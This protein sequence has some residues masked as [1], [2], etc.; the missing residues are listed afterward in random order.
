MKRLPLHQL[1]TSGTRDGTKF[2]RDDGAWATPTAGGGGTGAVAGPVDIQY[3]TIDVDDYSGQSDAAVRLDIPS[4]VAGDENTHPSVLYFPEQWNGWHYW[5]AFTPLPGHN[6][7]HEDPCIAVSQDGTQWE[8]P[9][10][11]TNP[12]DDATGSTYNSDTELAMSPDGLTLYCIWRQYNPNFPGAEERILMRS[13]TDGITW[14]ATATLLT[15]N[16]ATN[17]LASPAV[18]HDGTQWVMWTCDYV[19]APKVMRRHAATDI[20]GPWTTGTACTVTG[21]KSG[22]DIWHLSVV[23]LGA[24]YVGVLNDCSAGTSGTNGDLYLM[25]ST[26][27]LIWTVAT[28]ILF[29]RSLAGNYDSLYRGTIVPTYENGRLEFDLWHGAW[30]LNT[31]PI[32]WG[33]YRRRLAHLAAGSAAATGVDIEDESALVAADVTTLDF[34][35]AGV[36]VASAGAG[37]VVVTIPGGSGGA[38]A[39]EL[40]MQDGVTAPPVP[41]ETE[42]RDD[43]LYEG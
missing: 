18:L 1:A 39:G 6:D 32:R 33:I 38:G 5:M 9:A 16:V 15:A 24:Q 30:V 25:R 22:R 8:T 40:L 21:V 26:D 27:G 3:D 17:G 10:G 34:Q 43:W 13:S 19:A 42:A 2:L 36:S 29:A 4:H 7:D 28:D 41:L 37:A 31:G 23:Q 14:T 11:L 35:G 12:L 20:T